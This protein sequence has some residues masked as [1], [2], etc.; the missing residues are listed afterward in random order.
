MVDLLLARGYRG[1]GDRQSGRRP[2]GEPRPPRRRAAARVRAARHPAA[3]P[4][5]RAVQGRRA[6]LPLRRHRR[7]RAV[8]RAADRLHG[9]STSRAPSACWNARARRRSKKFVYAAS[10]SCY[11]LA[12]VPTREDHPIAPAVS[13]RAEQVPR[14]AGGAPLASGL[15]AAGQ[16]D[17]HLQRLRP[18]RRAPRRLRRGVRRLP[19]AEARRQAVHGG[20]RRHAAA[21]L[22]LRDRR[23]RGVPARG[24]N[25]ASAGR[26]G[27]SAPAIRSRS[28]GSSSCS[29]ARSSHIPKRPGEPDCTWADITQDHARSRLEA[30]GAVRRGCRPHDGGHRATGAMRRCGTRSRSR[31]ATKTWFEYLGEERP[32]DRWNLLGEPTTATRSRQRRS[33][34]RSIGDPAAQAQ[35]DHVPRHVRRRPSGAL[36][37]SALRQE[38]G[39]HSRRQPDRRPPHLQGTLSAARPAGPARDQSRRLRDRRLR[40][41]RSRTRRR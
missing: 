32:E 21:R 17:P 4:R 12:A 11:G 20:R 39:R 24:R 5:R 22:P 16:L 25:A 8:D 36:A 15:S 13:L 9:R 31:T 1:A 35:G 34:R 40:D 28:T 38:Q 33:L 37:A 10:S 41:H 18:A 7:H 6:R 29:A 27:T 19:P 2:R 26:S 23:R 3:R 30:E 14:R